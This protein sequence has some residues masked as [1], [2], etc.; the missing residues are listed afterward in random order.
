MKEY[1]REDL[2]KI[3]EQ[4]FV[5]EDKWHDRDSSSAQKQLGECYI[6]L[7][8][9]C[10][11]EIREEDSSEDT[12]V[13]DIYT[14]GFCWFESWENEED[15]TRDDKEKH[16]YFYLPTQKRLDEANGGDWY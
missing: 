14:K 5:S 7:K 16:N 9:G 4:A 10:E 15:R 3:C 1:T 13:L 6:F 2:I 12:I 11:Y 8:D